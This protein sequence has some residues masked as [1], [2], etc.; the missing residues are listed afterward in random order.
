[1][2]Y[3]AIACF[4]LAAILG[5]VLI[6]YIFG[7]KET[8]KGLAWIHGPLAAVGLILL[9]I[10]TFERANGPVLSVV[11]FTIAALGGTIVFIKD[12]K[13]RKPPKFLAIVHG[14]LAVVAFLALLFHVFNNP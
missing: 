3:T 7:N 11:L 2:I 1:M 10:Y 4:A 13:H 9:Y 5:V 8:P 12:I 14:A 6:A